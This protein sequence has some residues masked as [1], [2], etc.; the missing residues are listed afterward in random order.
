M[1]DWIRMTLDV[2]GDLSDLVS[3]LLFE[4]GTTGIEVADA[5]DRTHVRMT[6]YFKDETGRDAAA[7]ALMEGAARICK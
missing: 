5:E 4:S 6:A 1:P 2:P 7:A 3:G